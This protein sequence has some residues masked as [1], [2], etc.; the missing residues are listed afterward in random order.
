MRFSLPVVVGALFLSAGAAFA[1]KPVEKPVTRL[2]P[3]LDE[4]ISVD[5]KLEEL[6]TGFGF[7]EGLVWVPRG[8]S[9]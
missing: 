3:A 4:L 1:E 7:T 6:R 5:A 2:D 8:K 9:G